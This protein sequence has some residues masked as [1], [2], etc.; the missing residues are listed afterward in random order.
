MTLS[1]RDKMIAGEWYTCNDPELERLRA[2]AHVAIHEHNTMS[3]GQ[4]GSIGPALAELLGEVA[5]DVIV[6]APFHC[7]YGINIVLE[8]GVYINAGCT[9]L[10]TACV[11]VGNSSMLGPNV[12]IYCAEHHK[13]AAQRKAGLE[14]AKPV[15][16]GENVWIGGGSI[17]LGGVHIGDGAIIGAGAVVTKDVAAQA[18]VMGNPARPPA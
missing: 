4:R 10:D 3:P 13:D 16:I 11:R 9:I 5:S 14:I 15:E 17:I 7:A 6:E 2:R 18:T 8:Q 1:E 12:Q